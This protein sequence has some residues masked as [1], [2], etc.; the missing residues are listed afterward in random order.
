MSEVFTRDKT[1][2]TAGRFVIIVVLERKSLCENL[3]V[4]EDY[5]SCVMRWKYAIGDEAGLMLFA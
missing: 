3:L 4:P 1:T 2:M 5:Y